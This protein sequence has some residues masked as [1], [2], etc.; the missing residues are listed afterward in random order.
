M[1]QPKSIFA[2]V[3]IPMLMKRN[4]RFLLVRYFVILSA[5]YV[6]RE[7]GVGFRV[8]QLDIYFFGFNWIIFTYIRNREKYYRSVNQKENKRM[9][10]PSPLS[11]KINKI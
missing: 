1:M 6:Y 5:I 10:F 7:V 8:I 11:H 4:Y 3:D 9:I 2:V